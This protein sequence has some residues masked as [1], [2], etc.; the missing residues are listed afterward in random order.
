M[1]GQLPEGDPVRQAIELADRICTPWICWYRRDEGTV[2]LI[3]NKDEH[4]RF[5]EQV[6]NAIRWANVQ[7]V[8]G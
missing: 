2:E 8:I 1:Q 7:L 6:F 4:S 5:R 3:F